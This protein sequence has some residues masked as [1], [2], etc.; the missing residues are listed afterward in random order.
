MTS[1][2]SPPPWRSVPGTLWVGNQSE[3]EEEEEE[4][5]GCEEEDTK[6]VREY[7]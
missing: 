7:G 3:A 5:G 6:V 4:E 1:R 2:T